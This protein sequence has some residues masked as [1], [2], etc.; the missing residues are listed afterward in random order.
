MAGMSLH[1]FKGD[2]ASGVAVR[3]HQSINLTDKIRVEHRL[4]IRLAPVL[5]LPIVDPLGN[6]VN[7]VLT[8]AQNVQVVVGTLIAAQELL[9]C[10]ELTNVVRPLGNAIGLPVLRVDVP[11]PPCRAWI[12][13]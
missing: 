2:L 6:A 13:E 5:T 4:T 11:C 7:D 8:V 1:P 3:L 12:S 10:S 9:H